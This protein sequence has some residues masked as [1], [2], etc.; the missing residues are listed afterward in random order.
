MPGPAGRLRVFER[1][2]V[3]A[4]PRRLQPGIVDVDL[5][6]LMSQ[7]GKIPRVEI[8]DAEQTR[9]TRRHLRRV[10]G[11]LQSRL[12][13]IEPAEEARVIRVEHEDAHELLARHIRWVDHRRRHYRINSVA[14]ATLIT[15]VNL[16][17]LFA[18][19]ISPELL[20]RRGLL[21]PSR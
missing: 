16:A 12:P 9:V 13:A 20:Y 18:L 7:G 2:A 14:N 21:N 8:G 3:L 1:H 15:A 5:R 11:I 17:A 4:R 10:G 19:P 6:G